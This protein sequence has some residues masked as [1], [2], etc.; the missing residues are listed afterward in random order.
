MDP[1]CARCKA[2]SHALRAQDD[3]CSIIRRAHSVLDLLLEGYFMSLRA[4]TLGDA[5]VEILNRTNSPRTGKPPMSR[6]EL[7]K[8][9]KVSPST[10]SRITNPRVRQRPSDDLLRK[11]ADA[12]PHLT[13]F[14]TLVA[15]RDQDRLLPP[16]GGESRTTSGEAFGHEEE[17]PSS[18]GNASNKN[19]SSATPSVNVASTVKR[20]GAQALREAQPYSNSSPRD[21]A[22]SPRGV[23]LPGGRREE[24]PVE[25][26]AGA[27]GAPSRSTWHQLHHMQEIYQSE[28]LDRMRPSGGK[29]SAQERENGSKASGKANALHTS[30]VAAY[31][32][33][34]S[35]YAGAL[36]Q[37]DVMD[38]APPAIRL[39][40]CAALVLGEL[41]RV[42]GPL[43]GMADTQAA[44][45][46]LL[47][48]LWRLAV[49]G[50][51]GEDAE[52]HPLG[53]ESHERERLE[54]Y[55]TAAH[56]RRTAYRKLCEQVPPLLFPRGH[57]VELLAE[58]RDVLL[59]GF[60]LGAKR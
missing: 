60:T 9:L 13:S 33:T 26:K 27:H 42:A 14:E 38:G 29:T 40:V 56:D 41:D 24:V 53:L 18:G 6:V 39:S 36:S 1:G 19:V 10:L 35:L 15:L 58:L 59:R 50:Q 11:L 32:P 55:I 25:R 16:R 20:G 49:R 44:A 45:T 54:A 30:F 37:G 46:V 51:C 3:L 28:I 7:G 21:R 22:R 23:A 43:L 4:Q 34:I 48:D 57:T 31:L 52:I 8:I 47:H 2:V 17:F 5:I 12:F